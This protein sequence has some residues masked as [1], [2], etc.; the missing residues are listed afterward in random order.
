VP[1]ALADLQHDLLIVKDPESLQLLLR[2]TDGTHLAELD[3]RLYGPVVFDDRQAVWSVERPRITPA[4]VLHDSVS[5]RE[6]GRVQHRWI[7]GRARIVADGV[8]LQSA[9]GARRRSWRLRREGRLVA[10]LRLTVDWDRGSSRYDSEV[11]AGTVALY[12]SWA[13]TAELVTALVLQLEQIKIDALSGG[14]V[15]GPGG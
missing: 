5:G 6:L 9:A 13:I 2:K 14:E 1:R 10:T 7:P 11:L 12:G 15:A 4:L 8:E 3:R